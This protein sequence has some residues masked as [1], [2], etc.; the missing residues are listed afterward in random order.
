MKNT[1]VKPDTPEGQLQLPFWDEQARGISNTVVR[2]ALFRATHPS[3]PRLQMKKEPVPSTSNYVITY[4]GEELRQ[5]D[6]DIWMSIT[7]IARGL[8]LGQPVVFTARSILSKTVRSVNSLNYIRLRENL[9]RM[10]ATAITTSTIDGRQGFSGSLIRSFSWTHGDGAPRQRWEVE[11]DPKILLLYG[12]GGWSAL[13]WNLRMSLSPLGKWLHSFYSTHE[14][15]FEYSAAKLH[16]LCGSANADLYK[17][18]YK[19]Q[20]SLDIL[21]ERG[22][23]VSAKVDSRGMVSVARS[24][25]PMTLLNS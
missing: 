12:S 11:L 9:E 1:L 15:P 17:F 6:E 16:E 7:H 4:T 10:V 24:H 13:D 25:Q 3:S 5:D 2:C 19:L 20:Q 18:R 14:K 23:L 8:P 22:F 21:V